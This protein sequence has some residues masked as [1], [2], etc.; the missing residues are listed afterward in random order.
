MEMYSYDSLRYP[1]LLPD[2]D[3]PPMAVA[4]APSVPFSAALTGA[5]FL[6]RNQAHLL[7]AGFV[8]EALEGELVLRKRMKAS[9]LL[10]CEHL[11][12]GGHLDADDTVAIAIDSEGIVYFSGGNG[13]Y[14]ESPVSSLDPSGFATLVSAG[15]PAFLPENRTILEA[16]K[17]QFGDSDPQ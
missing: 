4:N 3:A 10:C 11:V 17:S 15:L 13:I 7:A 14:E 1:A 12:D 16:L 8:K 2:P 6:R 5:G 9:E